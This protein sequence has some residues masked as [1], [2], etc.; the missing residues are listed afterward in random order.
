MF[1]KILVAIDA[2]ERSQA[3]FDKAL[4]LAKATAANL[5]ILHVLSGEEE[6]SPTL[7][8]IGLE[9]YPMLASE[10]TELH[11]KQWTDYENRCLELLRSY[12]KQANAAGVTAEFTQNPGSPGRT[13]CQI[14]RAWQA[15]LIVMGRRGHSGVN[16]LLLGSV[17]NYVLHH[18][19]CSVLTVQGL[20]P[21]DLTATA[22]RSAPVE[23][24]TVEF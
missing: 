24:E 2:S 10:M 9:Y 14:A 6:G 13:I 16:E 1:H 21:A 19:P 15:D 20:I 5:M 3:V 23:S 7:S 22:E 4:D 11:R 17:S 18:A 12:A 8:L